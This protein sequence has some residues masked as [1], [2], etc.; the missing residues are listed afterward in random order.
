MGAELSSPQHMPDLH[1][2]YAESSP[3]SAGIPMQTLLQFKY[4]YTN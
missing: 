1:Q 4:I 3:H 2:D